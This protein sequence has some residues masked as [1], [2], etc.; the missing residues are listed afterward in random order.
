MSEKNRMIIKWLNVAAFLVM[1]TVNALANI[2]PINGIGT[3]EVSDTLYP[4]L[5][6]P[7]GL[8]FAI[9]GVI[10]LLL[11]VFII[12]QAGS[13]KSAPREGDT[14]AR[15]I[16]FWFILSSLANAAWIFCWHYQLISLSL[17]LMLIIFLALLA[18]YAEIR[19]HNL[20]RL[21]KIC[22]RLP[23]SVYFG[24]IT[25]ATIANITALLVGQK[26]NG[27]GLPETFWTVIAMAAGLLIG[28][29]TTWL[30][31]DLAYG[32]VFLW[33]YLGILLKHLSAQGFAG[34][35]PGLIAAAVVSLVLIMII[36]VLTAI[37][38]VKIKSDIL[39]E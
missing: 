34:Q 17:I 8:T 28:C 12:F 31:R 5:F 13:G 29:A 26:W 36:L 35:Y 6:A 14:I 33:A 3:G 30:N 18:I 9:W 16:S 21:E 2:L 1:L 4:N 23:F 25:V 39:Q 7:A 15:K 37:T 27:W 10:Y 32:L 38:P 22:V 19:L 20:S 11:A 24:W